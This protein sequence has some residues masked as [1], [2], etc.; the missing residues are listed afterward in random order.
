VTAVSSLRAVAFDLDGTLAD[1]L[2]LTFAAFRFA[3][4]PVLGREL[5]D[6]EIN[7]QFGP[8]QEGIIR[9]L[10]PSHRQ[11]CFARFLEFFETRFDACVKP[12]PGIDELLA[13]VRRQGLRTAVV[14]GAGEHPVA[15][16][17]TK[18]GL[19]ASFDHVLV[20][21]PDGSCKVDQLGELAEA[22]RCRP[23]EIAY[24]GDAP[25]DMVVA[26]DAGAVPLGAAWAVATD[27][28]A[29]RDAG[30]RAVFASPRALH[31]WLGLGPGGAAG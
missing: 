18:L 13:A 7:E 15:I 19:T 10:V 20:G 5:S 4:L 8:A 17:L 12:L 31:D 27:S 11:E 24:V 25:S 14:S 9:A 23:W 3:C 30:A 16:A 2:P 22:W 29:L 26:R 21:H 6:A 28:E 1:D